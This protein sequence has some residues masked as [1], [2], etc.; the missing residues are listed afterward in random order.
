MKWVKVISVSITNFPLRT[1]F[2]TSHRFWQIVVLFLFVSSYFLFPLWFP[3]WCLYCLVVC[4]LLS[5]FLW[6]FSSFHIVGFLFLYR[7]GKKRCLI[8]FQISFLKIFLSLFNYGCSHFPPLCSTALPTPHLPHSILPPVVFVHRSFIQDPWLDPSLLSPL[9]P[10]SPL[11]SLAVCSLFPCLWFC[12]ACL[13][14][15]LIRFHL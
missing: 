15:L 6:F 8:W 2:T 10:S 9:S 14:V 3:Y 11:W 12:F 1:T 5:R 4:C 13:S 7:S